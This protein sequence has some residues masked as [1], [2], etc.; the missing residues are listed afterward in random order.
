MHSISL[1]M[2]VKNEEANLERCLKSAAGYVDE[3]II[4]DTGSTDR[5]KEIACRYTDRVYDFIWED[6][7]STARNY[8]ISQASNEH[9]L[10]LDADEQLQS[11]DRDE[12]ERLNHICPEGIGRILIVS[13]Y[14]RN[15][16]TYKQRE[17]VSRL[18]SKELYQYEGRIHEQL[19]PLYKREAAQTVSITY[20]V[21]I[22]VEHLG[23]EGDLTARRSKTQR[24]I[25]LLKA[26]QEQ[27]PEDPYLLYQ[28]GKSF[29]MEEDYH[30][31]CEYFGHALY[32]DLDPRLEYVQDMVESYGYTLINTGQYETALQML[33]IYDEFS[34]S[35]DFLFLTG[36]IL[37]N[38]GKFEEAIIELEK[39]AEKPCSKVDGVNGYLAFYNIGVIY[40]CLG[41]NEN[42]VRYYKKCREYRPALRKLMDMIE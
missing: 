14:T 17:R 34:H 21:P 40:E 6:D 22:V 19:V 25:K 27:D 41:N 7:F 24:N 16:Y 29:Y 1:C 5:T 30:S 13:Q 36:L 8:S 12:V 37:M 35:A 18:F 2:I 15:N 10:V 3:M 31:A 33:N 23:Y 4:V 26:A 9:I 11:M 20:D 42:A 38:N 32:F 28:L 39:A